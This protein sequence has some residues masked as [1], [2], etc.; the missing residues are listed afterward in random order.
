MVCGHTVILITCA[1]NMKNDL[2]CASF[3]ESFTNISEYFL[4]TAVCDLQNSAV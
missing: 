3:N 2:S 1:I 4:E